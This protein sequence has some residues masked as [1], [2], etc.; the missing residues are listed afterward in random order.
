[1]AEKVKDDPN[2]FERDGVIIREKDYSYP[3]LAHLA[4][5]KIEK[6]ALSVLDLGG[7]LGSLYFQFKKMFPSENL[8][9]MIVEQPHYVA[10][11]H[12]LFNLKDLD[13]N[14]SMEGALEKIKPDVA[15]FSAALQYFRSPDEWLDKI[16]QQDIAYLVIDRLPV[17]QKSENKITIQYVP[18]HIYPASYPAWIFSYQKMLEKLSKHYTLIH[19]YA[20][21]DGMTYCGLNKVQFRG[22]ILA[23]NQT[24]NPA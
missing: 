23:R 17:C 19:D 14:D 15:I 24:L 2:C 20:A 9:W 12:S 4:K 21:L 3:V 6:G 16:S 13:F 22:F 10:K 18:K 5:W 8:S 1:M 11:G 7:S